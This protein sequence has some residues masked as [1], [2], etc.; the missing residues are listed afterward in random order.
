[1][2]ISSARKLR[3]TLPNRM[4][5]QW[6]WL[7]GFIVVGVLLG[8]GV[9]F[10]VTRPPR[11]EPIALLPPP[12]ASP[13]TVY[14]SGSVINAG[15][16]SL[17]VGSRVNDAI[18][19]AGGFSDQANTSAINLAKVL[20][21][22]EQIAVPVL[23]DASVNNGDSSPISPNVNLSVALININ[24]AT[25]EELDTLPGIGP[26]TSQDIIDYRKANGPF[27]SIEAIMDVPGIGQAKFDKIKELISVEAIP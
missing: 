23:N 7:A 13:V 2:R 9:L 1:M 20:E 25:L 6:F 4:N 16:Y 14:V 12:T 11:G 17:P 24:T 8:V 10:L 15:M 22:G 3:L 5:K 21:D 27:S 18:Q 26:I 19:A